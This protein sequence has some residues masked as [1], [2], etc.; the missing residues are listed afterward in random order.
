MG[1]TQNNNEFIEKICAD[2]WKELYRFIYY[3]VRNREEAQDITQETYTRAIS[4]LSSNDVEISDNINYLK[5]IS[6]NII[7]D[8]W[9]VKSRRGEELNLEEINP[10]EIASEDFSEAVGNRTVITAAI[11]QLTQDQQTVITLRIIKGYSVTATAKLMNRKEGTI[12]VLQFRAIKE[13][14]KILDGIGY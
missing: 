3:K 13:L 2:T 6:M 9:R 7:R 10:E 8:K 5:T 11:K 4:Y 12:R 1:N 14:T